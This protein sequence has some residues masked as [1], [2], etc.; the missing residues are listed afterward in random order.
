MKY[1]VGDKV[2]VINKESGAYDAVIGDVGKII[3]IDEVSLP[4]LVEFDNE[5]SCYHNGNNVRGHRHKDGHCYWCSEKMLELVS[6]DQKI[7]I[8]VDGST[9][10]A[11]LYEGKKV[12][13]IAEAK[14]A[15]D[16]K[17]DFNIGAK[18]A[19]ERLISIVKEVDRPAK[20]G[21]YVKVLSEDGHVAKKGEILKVIKVCMSNWVEVEY[22]HC[23]GS[24]TTLRREQ[25]VVVEN[26]KPS[27]EPAYY[28]GKIVCTKCKKMFAY[29]VGKI[30]EVKDGQIVIDNGETVP[31]VPAKSIEELKNKLLCEFIE[32]VE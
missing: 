23:Y 28:N 6:V 18:L 30:Y 14:C 29:T 17:F 20:V 3:T 2:K 22:E 8:T 24:Y 16:D 31:T 12:V 26:Y 4:Y 1:K 9:T 13:K 10:L 11:R 25:Y 32:V 7:V 27:E 5:R 19:F 15:P 21:E